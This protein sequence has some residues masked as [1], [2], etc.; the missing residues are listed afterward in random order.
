MQAIQLLKQDHGK[1]KAAFEE[2]EAAAGPQRHAM[3]TKL[4]P[5][6]VLH[7]KMEET[8]LYGP[9]AREAQADPT[10]AEWQDTHHQAVQEAER[11][12]KEIDRLGPS[13]DQWLPAVKKLHSALEQ[14]IRK[15][16]QEI[17]PKI[18]QRWD[19]ARLEEAGRSMEAMKNQEAAAVR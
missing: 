15:E 13:D 3:W 9:V 1:A 2:I 19:A 6:L 7:E 17:W 18:G 4:R 5:E 8:Y 10:F 12:I 11:L 16:E 14:H